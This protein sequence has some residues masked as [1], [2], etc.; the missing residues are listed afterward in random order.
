MEKGD[1]SGK[2]MATNKTTGFEHVISTL[3][4]KRHK[5]SAV[6]DFLPGCGRGATTNLKLNGQITVDQ[7]YSGIFAKERLEKLKVHG[8]VTV[9]A[10][11]SVVRV[12][13]QVCTYTTHTYRQKLKSRNPEW[14][15]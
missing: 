6:R 11:N 5:V 15:C 3:R 2:E 13:N 9:E 1:F 14:A 4:F 7:E 8:K 12:V 10:E